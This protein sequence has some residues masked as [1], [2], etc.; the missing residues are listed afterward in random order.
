MEIVRYI[1]EGAVEVGVRRDG[2]VHRLPGATVGGLL[3]QGLSGF[4][5][6]LAQAA[7]DPVAPERLLPPVDGRMEV[8]AAG[9]T[10]RRSREARMEESERSATIYEQVYDAPRPELFFKSAAWRVCGDGEPVTVRDDSAVDV[11][12]PE[13]ALVLTPAGEIAGYT[14]CNDLSSR[15]I[16]G[17]NPLYLPQAK[18]YLGGCAVGPAIRPSWEIEDPYDLAITASI[19][20]DGVAVWSGEAST[21]QLHRRFEDLVEHLFRADAFPDGAILST[22]T[23]LV[24]DLPFTLRHGDEMTIGIDGIG[25]LRNVVSRPE[26]MDYLTARV[27]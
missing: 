26:E 8:W 23:C 10:Y 11:P 12:E 18:V 4:R 27:G 15:S 16:E 5:A 2:V 22:G 25:V 19:V 9:V 24:P 7:P 6:A 3:R 13:L 17:E 21:G 14:V 1:S 20:R